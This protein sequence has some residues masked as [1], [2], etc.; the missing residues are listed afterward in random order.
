MVNVKLNKMM[1]AYLSKLGFVA[2]LLVLKYLRSL[3]YNFPS[4]VRTEKKQ[5]YI[6]NCSSSLLY[7][8]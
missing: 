4:N 2:L 8:E 1:C 3:H 5:G 7:L 6:F